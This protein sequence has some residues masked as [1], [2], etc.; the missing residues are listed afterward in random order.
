MPPRGRIFRSATGYQLM[1]SRALVSTTRHSV[2]LPNF[3]RPMRHDKSMWEIRPACPTAALWSSGGTH[4]RRGV[5]TSLCSA[6]S[7]LG[8]PSQAGKR[9]GAPGLGRASTCLW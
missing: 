2:S 5:W 1:L 3:V 7:R 8:R 6:P 9:K 4:S